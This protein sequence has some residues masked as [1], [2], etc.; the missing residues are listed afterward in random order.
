MSLSL[1]ITEGKFPSLISFSISVPFPVI[2]AEILGVDTII[3]H[4][5]F[6]NVLLFVNLTS[7]HT[8][9]TSPDISSTAALSA[10]V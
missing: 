8:P 4:L 3:F 7:I 9:D 6:S 2:L 5:F 1:S 10:A